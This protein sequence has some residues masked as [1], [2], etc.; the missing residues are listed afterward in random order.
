M[1]TITAIIRAKK[2]HEEAMRQ[3]LLDVAANVEKTNQIQSVSSF[4]KI[5][6]IP[7]SLR[8]LSASRTKRRWT[9][10]IIQTLLLIFLLSPDRSLMGK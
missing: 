9:D 6:V 8:P 2:G 4:H 7:A 1:L 10:T 3:G 5:R